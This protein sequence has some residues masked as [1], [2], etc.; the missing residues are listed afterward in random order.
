MAKNRYTF[1]AQVTHNLGNGLQITIPAGTEMCIEKISI[2]ETTYGFQ[3]R[4]FPTDWLD[5]STYTTPWSTVNPATIVKINGFS[6]PS[7]LTIGE[8]DGN[9]IGTYEGTLLRHQFKSIGNS[10]QIT[11]PMGREIQLVGPRWFTFQTG[12]GSQ[13]AASYSMVWSES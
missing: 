5:I 13:F 11:F 2:D 3:G 12:T 8:L 10:I 4:Q 9:T 7:A 1:R 6:P